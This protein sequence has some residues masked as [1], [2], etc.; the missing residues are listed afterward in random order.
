M[1]NSVI[2]LCKNSSF[3]SKFKH[4]DVRYH[5]IGDVLEE[6]KMHIEKIYT[7]ENGS[8]LMTKCLLREELEVW[9]HNA[10]LVVSPT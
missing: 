1:I 5:W 9:K 2:Q 4:I 7:D 6:K 10:N 8:D 3:H